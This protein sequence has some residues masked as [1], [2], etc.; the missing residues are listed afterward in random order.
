MH[1]LSIM[2]SPSRW[3]AKLVSAVVVSMLAVA[4]CSGHAAASGARVP[5]WVIPRL[6]A[7]ARRAAAVNGDSHP[8]WIT[9]VVTTRAKALTSATPGDYV[10]GS[11]RVR[12]FLIT[13]RG[14]FTAI[15]APGPPGAKAPAG[16]Y[17]SLVINAQTFQGLDFGISP[18]PP[19]V[20]P[21]SL[22]PVTYL[23]GW[24]PLTGGP[25]QGSA[26]PG[27]QPAITALAATQ[28]RSNAAGQRSHTVTGIHCPQERE[29]PPL[30]AAKRA[31]ALIGSGAPIRALGAPRSTDLQSGCVARALRSTAT[32]PG[33][34]S[35]GL[36]SV[37]AS[38]RAA[39]SAAGRRRPGRAFG[40]P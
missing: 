12:V 3:C 37:A 28:A 30:G 34:T 24:R 5:D 9:A 39:R 1:L 25:G 6:T 11:A 4:G 20:Q 8:E 13:M 2:R 16:R 38:R 26:S 27:S 23:V 32:D 35:S 14:H 33:G 36:I 22:G 17:V 31:S 19:P 15:S 18:G 7:I 21:D 29:Y 40:A 10:P